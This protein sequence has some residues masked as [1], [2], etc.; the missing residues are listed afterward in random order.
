MWQLP[1]ASARGVLFIA[2][3]CNHGAIDFFDKSASC[4]SC[5]GLPKEK[6]VAQTALELGLAVCAISS[7]DRLGSRCWDVRLNVNESRDVQRVKRVL[8]EMSGTLQLD[9]LPLY[10][11]GASSGGAF[12][13]VLP[14]ALPIKG[15]IIQVTLC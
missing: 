7:V 5:I 1:S 8:E 10:A 13:S 12:V 4:P 9:T 11:F 3:G 2:H 15:A 14:H 6:V